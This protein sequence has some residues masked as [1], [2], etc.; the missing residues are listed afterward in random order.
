[1][2]D[3]LT[4]DE[5]HKFELRQ[6]WVAML[7][8]VPMLSKE[9]AIALVSNNGFSSLKRVYS[10]LTNPDEPEKKR[11]TLLQASFGKTKGGAVRNEAKL[12]THIYKM[13]TT[14]DPEALVQE[15]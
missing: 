5:Q 8:M 4:P 7:Q 10:L 1:M 6:T 3:G 14:K 2:P 15:E 9:K 13:M 12:S 11:M